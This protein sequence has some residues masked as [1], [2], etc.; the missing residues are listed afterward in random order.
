MLKTHNH[1]YA[2]ADGMKTYRVV[3]EMKE[4]S[5]RPGAV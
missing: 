3:Y 2:Q 1:S 5:D 4:G